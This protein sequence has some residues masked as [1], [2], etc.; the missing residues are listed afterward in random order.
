VDR[1]ETLGP[2]IRVMIDDNY[3]MNRLLNI[4]DEYLRKEGL[5]SGESQATQGLN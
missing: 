3:V 2:Q 4:S 5:V 1:A